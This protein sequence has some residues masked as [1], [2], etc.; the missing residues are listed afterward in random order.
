MKHCSASGQCC[1]SAW[2]SPNWRVPPDR[3]FSAAEDR[4]FYGS[5]LDAGVAWVAA[6]IGVTRVCGAFFPSLRAREEFAKVGTL[7]GRVYRDLRGLVRSEQS[8]QKLALW[9]GVAATGSASGALSFI[10]PP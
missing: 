7:R 8:W 10:V 3:K 9:G 5:I 1:C 6:C 2:T 4:K